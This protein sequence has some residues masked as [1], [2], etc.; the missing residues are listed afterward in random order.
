MIQHVDEVFPGDVL[1]KIPRGEYSLLLVIM[2]IAPFI[3]AIEF[4]T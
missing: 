3:L 4:P 1:A 2:G